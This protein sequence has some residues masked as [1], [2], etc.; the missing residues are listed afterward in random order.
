MN[1]IAIFCHGVP[2]MDSNQPN[3][4]ALMHAEKLA[5]E[6][7]QV[8]I[9]CIFNEIYQSDETQEYYKKFNEKRS[10][11]EIKILNPKLGSFIK[12]LLNRAKL[13]LYPNLIDKKLISERDKMLDEFK[14]DLIINFFERAIELNRSVKMKKVNFLSI[15]LDRIELLRIRL[16]K[17]T[18]INFNLLNSIIF[19]IVYRI[20]I[21]YLLNDAKINFIS[22]PESYEIYKQ[23]NISNLKFFF[24]LNRKKPKNTGEKKQLLMIGNLKSTFVIDAL[25][26]LNNKLIF[27]LENLRKNYE[28]EIVIVGKFK[29]ERKKYK[30]LLNK[31]WIK[32][33]GW[34]DDVDNYFK[35]SLAL[36]VPSKYKLSVRT[37]ILDAFSSG[38]PVITYIGN[39]FDENLFINNE[40][41]ICADNT[42][43]LI[44]GLRN[45]LINKEFRKYISNNSFK[46][47]SEKINVDKTLQQNIES[48]KNIL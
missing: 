46:R 21:K 31:D 24:P 12:K 10:N 41:I 16:Q 47:Y 26:Q 48:I 38:L 13:K 7:Y 36:L 9:Y 23:F 14:P 44:V 6:G 5:N 17:L 45:I 19:I 29:E 22:C 25:I 4:D 3:A 27:E 1:K 33:K 40:N 42:E 30:N 28:F 35:D 37:K 34:V 18:K 11:I 32:F 8:K 15:P 39:N 2:N 43:S 20:R